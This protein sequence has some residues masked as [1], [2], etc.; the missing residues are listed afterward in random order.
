LGTEPI[1][2]ACTSTSK[3][4]VNYG[5]YYFEKPPLPKED[6]KAVLSRF[7]T[8]LPGKNPETKE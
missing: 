7:V 1:T 2:V 4:V 8:E 3:R 5:Q 6:M